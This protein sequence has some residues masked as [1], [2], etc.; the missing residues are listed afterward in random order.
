LRARFS[1]L[2]ALVRVDGRDISLG[3]NPILVEFPVPMAAGFSGVIQVERDFVT[4]A[5]VTSGPVADE[6][7]VLAYEAVDDQLL[8][9]L[10]PGLAT[11]TFF[12]DLVLGANDGT[13]DATDGPNPGGIQ[14]S[15]DGQ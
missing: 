7:E 6:V 12:R 1:T 10:L 11:T 14:V 9:D 8:S 13:G 4:A 2:N 15:V 5:R 3:P